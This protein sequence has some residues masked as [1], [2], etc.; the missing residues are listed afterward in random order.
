MRDQDLIQCYIR[1]TFCNE[2]VPLKEAAL[3]GWEVCQGCQ[4]V[5]CGKCKNS[6]DD[7]EYCPGSIYTTKHKA[8]FQLLP[9]DQILETA[10]EIE[11]PEKT[12]SYI[13]KIFFDDEKKKIELLK[14]NKK[15]EPVDLS[16]YR[17][18]E[19][20]W[21]KFGTVLVKRHDGKFLTWGQLE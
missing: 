9:V 17:F 21:R 19:E 18:R 10:K 15:K 2:T 13:S 5:F 4:L 20:Q 12:G 16:V 6:A 1:C 14:K 11:K 8:I 7:E 3:E